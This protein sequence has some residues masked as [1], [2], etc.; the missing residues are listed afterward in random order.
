MDLHLAI[1]A[2]CRFSPKLGRLRPFLPLHHLAP[3]VFLIHSRA[4]NAASASDRANRVDVEH[5]GA[6]IYPPID[7]SERPQW[8]TIKQ[9]KS[10][11]NLAR[12]L[13]ASR[14]YVPDSNSSPSPSPVVPRI[15]HTP[16]PTTSD[17]KISMQ[18]T[19]LVSP[20]RSYHLLRMLAMAPCVLRSQR[21]LHLLS[22]MIH[23]RR[24][25]PLMQVLPPLASLTSPRSRY[26]PARAPRA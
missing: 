19:P 8:P 11:T 3:P 16:R 7:T 6:S 10:L 5:P 14:I 9:V 1:C 18:P 17:T 4:C 26:R 24:I 2:P 12:C 25:S 21:K 22:R 20:K 23:P 13:S 15:H